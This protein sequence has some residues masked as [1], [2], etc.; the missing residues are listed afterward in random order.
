MSG[1]TA[2]WSQS[3]LV[4][5]L[6]Q[7]LMA[8]EEERQVTSGNV[9]WYRKPNKLLQKGDRIV[10]KYNNFGNATKSA[11]IETDPVRGECSKRGIHVNGGQCYDYYGY[12][13]VMK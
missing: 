4:T 6:A 2:G 3:E 12:T 10:T 11:K 13:A 9:N 5:A 7:F 1:K 8:V